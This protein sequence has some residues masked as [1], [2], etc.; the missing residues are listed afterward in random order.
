VGFESA[1]RALSFRPKRSRMLITFK[2]SLVDSVNVLS[3][4]LA[5]S[6]NRRTARHDPFFLLLAASS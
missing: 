5:T 3:V 6:L 4:F 2:A 1:D